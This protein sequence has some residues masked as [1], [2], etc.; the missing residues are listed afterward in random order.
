MARASDYPTLYDFEGQIESATDAVLSTLLS[1]VRKPRDTDE[2]AT[3][4]CVAQF[5]VERAL[6]KLFQ[7][8]NGDLRHSIYDG[9]LA[10]TIVTDR[11]NSASSHNSFRAKV[12]TLMADYRKQFNTETLL[13]Y[14]TMLRCHETSGSAVSFE[15]DLDHSTLTFGVTIGIKEE[16]WPI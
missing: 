14:L 9:T 12:R 15:N 16:A 7:V 10:I 3:P 13:P 6:A 5:T 1:D 2:M 8:P 4:R 11:R